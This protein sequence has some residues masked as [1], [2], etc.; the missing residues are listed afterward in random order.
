MH[1]KGIRNISFR[2]KMTLIFTVVCTFSIC[3]AGIL[4][5]KLA[6]KEI[7]DNF[8]ANA[9]SLVGQM[10]NTLDTR[11]E[12]VN[13]RAF[14]AL[15]NYAFIQPLGDYLDDPNLK[16]EV[17]LSGEAAYWL[18]D[19]SLAEPLVNSVMLYTKQ[20]SW[21]DYT[22][23][24]NWDFQFEESTFS[25]FFKDD[26]SDAVQW[27]PTMKDEIFLGGDQVIPY[28]RR[29]TAGQYKKEPAYLIVQLDKKVLLEEVIG[30]S[31]KLGEILIT[32]HEG[33]YI[34]GT[35]K[36]E[37]MDLEKLSDTSETQ[38]TVRYQGEEYLMYQGTVSINDWQIYILKS[39]SELLDSVSGM[40]RLIVGL[41]ALII[42]LCLVIVAF[43][44]RQ[45][46][47]S[48]QRLAVQMNRMRNGELEA[49][50]Y[51]PYKDEVGSLAKTFNYMADE[52]EKSMKK[53]EEYIE[54]LKEERDFVEQV[55]KQK[56]KAELRALQAQINPHFLY[57]TL[58][59]ITWLASDKGIDEIRIL[60]HS[61]GKFFRI[62]LSRGA[63]VITIRD[64]IEH[65]KS[66]LTIQGIR[67]SEVMRYEI[68]LPPEIGEYTVLKLVLQPL[69]EN[70]IYHGIKE[71]EGMSL[72]RISAAFVYDDEGAGN[73]VSGW[74]EDEGAG[75]SV[76]G[77]AG[78][79][80]I[81]RIG[82][83][84]TESRRIRF[85]VEDDGKGI[86]PDKL[87]S[88]NR[89]LAEGSAD[90]S[91][92]YGIFNVNERIKLYYGEEYGLRYESKAGEWTKAILTIPVREQEESKCIRY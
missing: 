73:S 14:A 15:T 43:M 70:A 72:I 49:R 12:A 11:L 67:Y 19:I 50:F 52:M 92:G 62:S 1:M 45:L 56:R 75:N 20:K 7:V 87:L 37:E 60:S 23:A 9:E 22:K 90:K 88:I 51:Y 54:V 4:Y 77:E 82:H 13:R 46:T 21:D 33:R 57:N 79:E 69:V 78:D 34:A 61:L 89:G 58:N 71:K 24:R 18:K 2:K 10:E 30:S 83:V 84:G 47:S 25:Q 39:R 65:V 80:G 85:V 35:M 27:M 53:Q 41:T 55:Q 28:V 64:E 16:K 59:T 3:I 31:K 86:E 8:K 38:N 48:L 32:D 42:G 68:E 6:E 44:A 63:E 26:S 81:E 66:Y 5:Y 76:S 17:I 36:E 29:F 91:D 74:A 40:R